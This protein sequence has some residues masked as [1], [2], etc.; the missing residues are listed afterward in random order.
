MLKQAA[1]RGE[2]LAAIRAAAREAFA[3]QGYHGTSV[4][5]IAARSGVSMAAL[6]YH[7]AG[8]KQELLFAVLRE[9]AEDYFVVC[10][11]A[12]AA[13][14]EEPAARLEALVRTTVRYRVRRRTES[15]LNLV[16]LRNLEPRYRKLLD[17]RSETATRM[18]AGI[19]ADGLATGDFS[20]PWPDDAR[21]AII[22]MCNAIADWYRP[23]GPVTVGELADR[24][25]SLA[26]TLLRT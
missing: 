6:Y 3:E 24:Y 1:R 12:L 10:E 7:Y 18:W 9:A 22:A 4:R 14:S 23:D 16:E 8:G 2:G 13:A 19:I 21:R 26:L 20:T 25:A 5:D 15:S 17:A 11:Q